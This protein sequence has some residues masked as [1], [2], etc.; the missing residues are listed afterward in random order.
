MFL[1]QDYIIE[2]IYHKDNF[3]KIF[4]ENILFIIHKDDNLLCVTAGC[5]SPKK[6]T[7]LL[8]NFLRQ[9]NPIRLL[10]E[11]IDSNKERGFDDM[12]NNHYNISLQKRK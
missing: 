7:S 5:D 4:N 2:S 6:M 8:S 12:I 1:L 11:A 9:T 10:L 3:I